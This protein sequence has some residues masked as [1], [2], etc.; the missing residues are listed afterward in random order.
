M[1]R[2]YPGL[3]GLDC[4]NIRRW[5]GNRPST[6]DGLPIIGA[7][8]VRGLWYG[9]GHG[10]LGLNAA[11]RTAELLVN[12]VTGRPSDLNLAPFSPQR[13]AGGLTG[14]RSAHLLKQNEVYRKVDS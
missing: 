14:R 7:G 13:F 6:P 2:T 5:Q 4:S 8:S 9:F 1:I 11:P 10:H 12:L 3:A